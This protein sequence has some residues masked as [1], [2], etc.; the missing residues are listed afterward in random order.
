MANW[1]KMAEMFGED[2][3]KA[4]K[5]SKTNMG[6]FLNK[7]PEEDAAKLVSENKED[8]SKLLQE[9]RAA[10]DFDL[11]PEAE[12]GL[13]RLDKVYEQLPAADRNKPMKLTK[14][15]A[16]EYFP[17]LKYSED[18]IVP[19]MSS[20]KIGNS[21]VSNPQDSFAKK[22]PSTNQAAEVATRAAKDLG[23]ITEYALD[24]VSVGGEF[25]AGDIVKRAGGAVVRDEAKE[26]AEEYM[27]A[28]KEKAFQ[29]LNALG[30]P[31]RKM[32]E[33]IASTI[34]VEGDKDNSEKSSQAIIEKMAEK[35][36][37]P[38]ESV[39]GNIGKALGVAGLE[40]F[41]DPLSLVPV[42]KLT[43]LGPL[44]KMAKGSKKAE[45][46]AEQAAKMGTKAKTAE[47]L[48]K[49]ISAARK[50]A[51]L[52]PLEEAKN[53]AQKVGQVKKE[54]SVGKVA[55]EANLPEQQKIIQKVEGSKNPWIEK[56]AAQ[57]KVRAERLQQ[58]ASDR[59]GKELATAQKMGNL[60]AIE[61]AKAK[62]NNYIR[63]RMKR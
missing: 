51:G 22:V 7:L 41:A 47:E 11:S 3:V 62:M 59:F 49:E 33:K 20:K 60:T 13:K 14:E 21:L 38:E 24:P 15:Q 35:L 10:S 2:I 6:E 53:I 58:E 44:A 50:A 56:A 26:Q 1:K 27:P 34:G 32:L 61:N 43:K 39:I 57:D 42:G 23:D 31:Q 48:G 9:R 28:I 19:I 40:V 45:L 4:I 52:S 54:A 29:A 55:K 5:N 18:D 12:E 63:I 37:I 36:G 30:A 16:K 17:R 25:G 46:F 8:Y